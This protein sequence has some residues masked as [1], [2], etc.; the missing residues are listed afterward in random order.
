MV[1]LE[2]TASLKFKQRNRLFLGF[3]KNE[4]LQSKPRYEILDGLR[5]V[6][7]LMVIF[8]H[9]FETY[10]SRIGTQIINHG[11]L[12]VD[13]FFALSGFVIGYAYDDRWGKMTTW[14]FFKRRL[15]R[16]H[17]MVIA[18]TV[19]GASL[20]F[21]GDHAG[22]PLIMKCPGWKFAL[23]FVMGLFMIPAGKGLD[24]RGWS[25]M[26]SFNGP[27]WS[28]T[29][30]YVGNILY[31][32]LFRRLPTVVLVVLCALSAALTLDLTLG[33]DIFGLFP[34]KEFTMPDGNV[35]TFGGPQ[36]G[37][38]GGWSLDAQQMYIGFT[39]LLY[40]FLS[41]LIISRILPKRITQSNPSG[42]PIN[43]RGGFWWA[44]LILVV[45]FSIPCIGGKEGVANGLY[46]ALCILLVFPIVVLIGAGGKTTNPTSAKVCK[47]LG[48]LSYPL[49]ITHY[50][51]MYM[52]MAWV[53]NH[54]DASLWQHIILNIGVV[55]ISIILAWTVYK[56]YDL[57]V[58][59]WLTEKVLKRSKA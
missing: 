20:F 53:G 6:A 1:A 58:R 26:N 2:E 41:G 39:R 47:F 25:E 23:C 21:F 56:A 37:V 29:F 22:F 32:F 34:A 19:I 38:I 54:P 52:Q 16:L 12:A 57:P 5:G 35:M 48:E 28:L 15:V 9:C 11:F 40:P 10:N 7:A 31:A 46:Q 14:G 33:W 30:E 24:I 42:S 18:G 51:F 17:P 50:P 13:F 59:N 45:I 8:F 49:Y 43:L 27:N 55:V 4:Y 36:Y 3:M 44:S